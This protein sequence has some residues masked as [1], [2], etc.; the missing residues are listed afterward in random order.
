MN[1]RTYLKKEKIAITGFGNIKATEKKIDPRFKQYNFGSLY[2]NKCICSL[3]ENLLPHLKNKKNAKLVTRAAHL[4]EIACDLAI[5]N[6]NLLSIYDPYQT[7]I[8]MGVGPIPYNIDTGIAIVVNSLDKETNE[9]SLKKLCTTG[10]NYSNPL[11]VLHYLSGLVL[12]HC[13][14]T[15]QIKGSNAVFNSFA[16]GTVFALQ[17]AMMDLYEGNISRALVG[18]ADSL[19]DVLG[20]VTYANWGC[21]NNP[22]FIP[23]EAAAFIVLEK[24]STA[25]ERSQKIY[26]TIDDVVLKS[27]ANMNVDNQKYIFTSNNSYSFGCVTPILD[28][29]ENINKNKPQAENINIIINS[30]NLMKAEI[31]LMVAYEETDTQIA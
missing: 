9:L 23:S 10:I 2:E 16:A 29:I 8:Y 14:L 22:D 26:A 3:E 30:P 4:S 21:F 11:S 27:Q 24:C 31:K 17:T 18:A 19:V 1:N 5:K 20:L 15:F 28:I 6:A 12:S 13:A 7:G 25:N